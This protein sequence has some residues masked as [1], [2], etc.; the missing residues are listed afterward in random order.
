MQLFV[1]G[2]TGRTGVEL[3]DLALGRAHRVTAFVRSPQKM[4]RRDGGLTIL[5]GDIHDATRMAAAMAGHDAVVSALGPS[6]PQAIGG[7]TLM[8]DSTVTALSAMGSAGV[9]R[10][11]V[12]S[13]ALLFSGGGL[14]VGFFRALIGQ[15]L[16]DLG[17]METIILA[18]GT[19]WTIARPP[20]LVMA[21]DE[22]YTAQEGALPDRLAVSVAMSWRA[23]AAFLL[24]SVEKS[25]HSQKIVGLSRR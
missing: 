14:A 19:R 15:H 23:V 21:R 4:T 2:A 17:E 22:G 3:I 7:T 25:L 13:S 6:V 5:E 12:V 16:R 8:R 1:L 9:S 10:F 18:S 20:R 11:L 24:D